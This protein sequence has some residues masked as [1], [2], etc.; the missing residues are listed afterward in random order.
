MKNVSKTQTNVLHLVEYLYLGGIE[1]L[2]EQLAQQ[3]IKDPKSKLH[4]FTYESETVDGIGKSIVE[5]G[6]PVFYCKKKPGTDFSLVKKLVQA[7][8]ENKIDVIHTHDFGP[9]EYAL[10]VKL[11]VPRVRLIHTQHTIIHFLRN[12][13][14]R[15]FFQ[16]ASYFF[17]T[18]ICVSMHVRKEI[19]RRCLLVRR[20]NLKVISNGVDT[21]KFAFSKQ[22]PQNDGVLRMVSVARISYEKNMEYLLRTAEILKDRGVSF[23]LHHAGTG[24]P[25]A[26]ARIKNIIE[27]KKLHDVVIL[28]G[29][30][31]NVNPILNMADVFV[32][33]SIT[34]GHPVALLEAMARGKVCFCSD[35]PPHRE[36][37][38]YVL[39][40]FALDKEA[41]LADLLENFVI[42]S[43]EFNDQRIMAREEIEKRFSLNYM[44]S[45]YE[46]QYM[47]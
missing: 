11:F 12:W 14:Y 40:Y 29:Y 27:Q 28:H 24:K 20:D 44:V 15:W 33:S 18:V 46:Q 38:S 37:S 8:K 45:N 35:I 47:Q 2:L 25:E 1:R 5:M 17:H 19:V 34:E 3:S 31:D 42:H 26:V 7:V 13:K 4:F 22:L 21:S 43:D 16:F 41:E 30:T 10:L 39:N 36:I 6:F 9:I 32:T 23:E